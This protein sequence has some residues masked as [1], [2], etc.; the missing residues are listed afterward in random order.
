MLWELTH[1][2]CSQGRLTL[3]YMDVLKKDAEAEI[4]STSPG[5]ASSVYFCY[6]SQ[7]VREL[8]KLRWQQT[9]LPTASHRAC[10]ST[11]TYR[12]CHKFF[13]V[14]SWPLRPK[15]LKCVMEDNCSTPASVFDSVEHSCSMSCFMDED[16]MEAHELDS[17][18]TQPCHSCTTKYRLSGRMKKFK[19]VQTHTPCPIHQVLS[20]V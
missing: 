19:G 12:R 18:I 20:S 11:E 1:G 3:T 9:E 4:G 17:S 14:Y 8:D 5:W 10:S 7:G 2:H 15:K 13:S 6:A 16:I